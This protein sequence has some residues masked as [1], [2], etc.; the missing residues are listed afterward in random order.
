MNDQSGSAHRP[1]R[2]GGGQ[3]G[4]GGQG[5]NIDSIVSRRG[6][7]QGGLA[8]GLGLALGACGDD[9]GASSTTSGASKAARP[10]T[11]PDK[12]VVRAWGDP[13]ST[14]IQKFAGKAFTDQTGIKVEYDLSDAGE[15]QAKVKRALAAGR[16]PPVD[17]VYTIATLAYTADVQKLLVPLNPEI[18]TNFDSL[19]AP[20]KPV[21]GTTYANLYSYS[22]PVIFNPKETSFA[23]G[24]SWAELADPKYKGGLVAGSG[25][26]AMV[27]PYAKMLGLDLAKD[28]LQP[29]WDQIA[30]LQP[31]VS[32]VGDDTV[33]I[34]T[35]K[36]GDSFIGSALVGDALAVKDGGV[37][38]KWVVPKEGAGLLAD[39]MYVCRGL[40]DD[41]TYY[42]QVFVNKVIDAKIQSQ[43]CEKVG[44]VPTNKDA[45][46]AKFMLGDPAF[47]FT[48]EEIEKYA[49]PEPVAVVAENFDEW[50]TQYSAVIKA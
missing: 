17:V 2:P 46:P 22:M 40:P 21:R 13:Y 28:D 33:F 26:Q 48:D 3:P 14:N 30:K 7:L 42:A 18:V 8:V 44:T 9:G 16:R 47:P 41:V 39:S 35:M 25:F 45:Q 37:N 32:V 6:V 23:E 4:Q 12:L 27:Y 31:N 36:S 34:E 5:F 38:V 20:G 11:K 43:W 29:V 49:I 19:T 1:E 24:A 15:I 10:K 50:N